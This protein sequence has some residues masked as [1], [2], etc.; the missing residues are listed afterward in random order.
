MP[1][2]FDVTNLLVYS[3]HIYDHFPV[4]WKITNIWTFSLFLDKT[5]TFMREEGKGK[6]DPI[7]LGGFG[8]NEDNKFWHLIIKYL[9]KNPDVH[10]GYW[11]YNGY[12]GTPDVDELGGILN[13]DF[14]TI[15]DQY[16]IED[17]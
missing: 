4:E 15:R 6:T 13:P 14:L 5:V 10:W 12:K 11:A 2:E 8:T 16:R 1:N 7:W 9:K 17:L 3:L